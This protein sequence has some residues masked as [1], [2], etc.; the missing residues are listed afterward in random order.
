[1]E[2]FDDIEQGSPE[3]YAL[4]LG[5][6]TASMFK[7]LL[8]DSAEKK[9]RTSYLYKLAGERLTGEPAESFSNADMERGKV[10]E[11]IIREHYAFVR[12]CENT[13]RQV[14]FIRNGKCGCSPDSL[15]GEDGVLEIKSAAPHILIPMLLHPDKFPAEHRAQCQGSL[16]VTERRYVDLIVYCPKMKP[17]IVRLERDED[18]IQ[19]LRDAVDVFELELRRLVAKLRGP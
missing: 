18:Y 17:L 2:I 11:P 4:R 12:D 6:P 8:V 5:L 19:Q 10:M 13:I 15:L 16:M 7:T 3:W 1:M 9:T 14:A